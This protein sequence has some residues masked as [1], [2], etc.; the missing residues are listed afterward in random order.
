MTDSCFISFKTRIDHLVLSDSLND[1]FKTDIPAICSVAVQE[2]QHYLAANDHLW[3]HNF[4]V[5][6]KKQPAKGKMFG[7]LVVCKANGEL[8]YLI[9]FSG[10]F[11]DARQPVAFVPSVFDAA[12]DNHFIDRGM[13]EISQLSMQISMLTKQDEGPDQD[14]ID[15]LVSIRKTHSNALQQ[16]L[17]DHYAFLNSKKES[18]SLRAIFA[19]SAH[20]NPP[21]AAGECAAPKLLQYAFENNLKPLEIA[22]FWW[23][24][25][26]ESRERIHGQFYPACEDKCRPI[27]NYM[28]EKITIPFSGI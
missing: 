27:L 24:K 14:E 13:R 8:G 1:P 25:S 2:V 7:V 16:K 12:S 10:K 6:P 22:E 15:R 23:G 9:A 28:L 18:Q 3:F 20:P 17:F 11:A 5:T 19:Q 4:G 21:A 26:P